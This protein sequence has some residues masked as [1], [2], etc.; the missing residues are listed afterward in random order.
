[1]GDAVAREKNIQKFNEDART[2]DGYRYTSNARISSK[3]ANARISRAV[4]QLVDLTGKRVVDVGC[5]DGTY[6]EELVRM[7]AASVLGVDAAADAIALAATRPGVG[8]KLEFRVATVD[9]LAG[10]H[11]DVAVVRGLLHHLYEAGTA[12]ASICAVADEIIVIEPNGYNPVL[13][14]IEKVSKYHVEHEEKSFPP[15]R[16][17]RW[18][19]REGAVVEGSLF[20]GLVPFF[21]PDAMARALKKVEPVFERTPLIRALSCAQYVQH[22]STATRPRT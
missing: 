17:D 15:R 10:E 14:V 3:M 1:L 9:Q 16:L 22:I 18:F 13:K 12:A 8:A 11:F 21:C 7:G 6:T 20:I 2:N 19:E 5:G 4:A